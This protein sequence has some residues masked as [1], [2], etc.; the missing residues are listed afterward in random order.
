LD[1]TF[2]SNTVSLQ[3]KDSGYRKINLATVCRADGKRDSNGDG[4][5]YTISHHPSSSVKEAEA[6]GWRFM[7][8]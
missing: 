5:P 7:G 3:T 4:K 6:E 2:Q 8:K 1:L